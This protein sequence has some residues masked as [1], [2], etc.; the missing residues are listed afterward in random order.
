[1]SFL[2]LLLRRHLLPALYI[3]SACICVCVC[4]AVYVNVHVNGFYLHAADM[5]LV[6]WSETTDDN[7][8][9]VLY[10]L[11]FIIIFFP[12]LLSRVDLYLF[13]IFILTYVGWHFMI[14]SSSSIMFV[15]VYV[16]AWFVHVYAFPRSSSIHKLSC[17]VAS[18][19]W[20]TA[21]TTKY[22]TSSVHTF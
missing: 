1:M 11:V 7:V 12:C 18:I 17:A 19:L 2:I 8:L 14:S 13:P 3:I 15:C 21:S 16:C 4:V 9:F 10:L 5:W 6:K 20:H 22:S